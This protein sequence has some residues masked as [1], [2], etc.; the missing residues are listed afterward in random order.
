MEMFDEIYLYNEFDIQQYV[1]KH[2]DF[3]KK[4]KKDLVYGYGNLK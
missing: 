3:I 1:E 2:A 4:I